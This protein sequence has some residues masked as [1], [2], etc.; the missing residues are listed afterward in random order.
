MSWIVLI[1]FVILWVLID[2]YMVEIVNWID[3]MWQ[4]I[5]QAH[6][7]LIMNPTKKGK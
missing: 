7:N 2:E 1:L 4:R 3:V 5:K 6:Y